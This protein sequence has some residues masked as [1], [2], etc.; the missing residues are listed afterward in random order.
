MKRIR[1][2]VATLSMFALTGTALAGAPSS[3]DALADRYN[4][5]YDAIE[6]AVDAGVVTKKEAVS[7]YRE[8]RVFR[9]Q[10]Q[11]FGGDGISADESMVLEGQ[12]NS[13]QQMIDAHGDAA[14]IKALIAPSE[15]P[16]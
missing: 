1:I 15:L 13:I 4:A 10:Y 12:L 8:Q 3:D 2:L 11:Q 6:A 16:R 9:M 7:L 14:A 5:Q